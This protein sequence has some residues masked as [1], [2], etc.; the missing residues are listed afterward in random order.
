MELYQEEGIFFKMILTR[1]NVIAMDSSDFDL[2]PEDI[3]ALLALVNTKFK[4]QGVD[5][6]NPF[7]VPSISPSGYITVYFRFIT[8]QLGVMI[9]FEKP[10]LVPTCVQ[11]CEKIEITLED[12]EL[13]KTLA[14]YSE[15]LPLEPEKLVEKCSLE[16][17][18]A[19]NFQLRQF[20][21]F[22]SMAYSS[23][24]KHS[25]R[26]EQVKGKNLGSSTSLDSRRL[27][28]D[29]D[30]DFTNPDPEYGSKTSAGEMPEKIPSKIIKRKNI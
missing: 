24:L 29:M 10:E 9:L 20:Q 6:I 5:Y 3:N 17:V 26:L 25:K 19:F 12:A 18:A 21:V 27:S 4:I 7:C 30:F 15:Q 23:S 14:S 2:T 22:D 11:M 8:P 1:H 16:N 28:Q 13:L